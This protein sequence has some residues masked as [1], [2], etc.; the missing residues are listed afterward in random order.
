MRRLFG[1]PSYP[2][3]LVAGILVLVLL[4][5]LS[6]GVPAFWLTR[7]EL[8]KQVQW[9][10]DD[11]RRATR[12]LL[13]AEQAQLAGV[14]ALLA[15]RPTLR[16]LLLQED[17]DGLRPYLQTFQAQG[18]IDILFLCVMDEVDAEARAAVSACPQ[19]LPGGSVL[20]Q[21]Q[22]AL[23]ASRAIARE[24]DSAPPIVAFAGQ[25]LDQTFLRQLS[26][27]T[28]MLPSILL[29]DGA[30]IVSGM[31]D[32]G[33]HRFMT[34]V[35]PLTDDQG[36]ATLQMEL[37]L[38]VD[39][40][41]AAQRRAQA[42]LAFST[43]AVALLG[44]L[45]GIWTVRRLTDP[46]ELLTQAADTISRG[47]LAAP[48]PQ[49]TGPQEVRTL[50]AAL[51]R[52]QTSM[53]SALDELAQAH[54]WLN[55]LVQSIA[56]GVVTVDEAGRVTLINERAALLAGT[57][58][59]EAEGRNVDDLFAVA[60]ESGNRLSLHRL[61]LGGKQ[62]VTLVRAGPGAVQPPRQ[63]GQRTIRRLSR[64]SAVALEPLAI[65]EV[66]A[67]RL[68]ASRGE[69]MQTA[70]VLRD[71]SQEES[72]SQ[73]RSYFLANI[74]HEFRTPLSTVNASMELLMNEADLSTSEVHE[75]LKPIH[76]SLLSLQTLI[77]N[78]L[79]SS[80]IE[81]GRFV[82]RRQPVDLNQILA[83]AVRVVQPLVERRRQTLSLTEPT[84]LPPL[85][86]DP[87]R[88]TQAL[89][90]LLSNASKYGPFDTV[91]AVQIAHRDGMVRVGVA[92]QGPGIPREERENLFR[93][94]VRL[95]ADD[96]EQYGIGLGLYVV[97]T[98]VEAHEG[99][100]G[101]DEN[102]NGGS[103]FWFELPIERGENAV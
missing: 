49:L 6:A 62:R 77:D 80:S 82:L 37:A 48:V 79:E 9:H 32:T 47:D 53:L 66:T 18:G 4:T 34:A 97:K 67:V 73:L 7:T 26:S 74:T 93:R 54:D 12:S 59:K 65:L 55:S 92:D 41:Y 43:G 100:V 46:L 16:R 95:N 61:P 8:A 1:L 68:R 98:T 78:L 99:R 28:G 33:G 11:A 102:P 87:P 35:I 57:S 29:A 45:L 27:D 30:R 83:D 19:P 70:L 84:F 64:S 36:R 94:F 13:R 10:L 75:L 50:A 69:E 39:D 81:A 88:L 103:L 3:R 17:W 60:D 89:V 14:L 15:E 44:T 2:A 23:L 20:Y 40:F 96:A 52:S 51:Q 72:L 25:W 5:T 38:L 31:G 58:I 86:G 22:P 63:P 85:V 21:G 71:I 24:N 56:E 76:L 90:N 91:I 101:V 42:I